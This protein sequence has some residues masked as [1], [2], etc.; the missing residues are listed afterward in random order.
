VNALVP[1]KRIDRAIA[2]S[3]R[4]GFPLRIVGSG[5][6][7]G[8]LR[9]MASSSVSFEKGLS[10]EDLRERY[11]ECAFLLQPG[12]EDFGIAS[13]EAMA[14]G[15]PVVA[16][17]RGGVRDIVTA[18]DI[19]S[20]YLDEEDSTAGIDRA[21]D[22]L[23]RLGFNAEGARRNAER[24]SIQRFESDFRRELAAMTS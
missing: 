19:G 1:Y 16:L 17:D 22:S 3:N 12:E 24:F 20:L 5:P 10:R 21:I 9:E 11:R 2:W 7:E 4:T 15:R 13:V 6:E 14:C 23:H 18:R 8:R